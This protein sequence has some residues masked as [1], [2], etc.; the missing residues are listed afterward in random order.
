MRKNMASEIGTRTGRALIVLVVASWALTASAA[1][2]D[3]K[4]SELIGT[5]QG[6]STCVDRVAAPACRDEVVV[7]DFTVGAQ[8]GT[9]QWKAD[10]VVEGQ[11]KPMG[12]M[13][14]VYE[15]GESC[16]VAEFSSP[17]GRVAWCLVVDG[18][19]MTG[20]GRLLPG[21][22]TIRRIDVRKD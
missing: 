8:P 12:E 15:P 11:R 3:H 10:K 9:V 17:R 4:P 5:W 22:Q 7:Y 13:D 18:A 21:K 1:P 2:N 6:T 19:H 16:W 14:L 20:T